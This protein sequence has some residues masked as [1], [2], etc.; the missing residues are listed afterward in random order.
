MISKILSGVA[1]CIATSLLLISCQK[2]EVY[3]HS[4]NAVANMR[5][6]GARI[7]DAY[8]IARTPMIISN[9]FLKESY[10]I[11][12][13][14]RGKP[15]NIL[16]SLTISSPLNNAGVSGIINIIA[17]ATDNVGVTRV[18]F[19]IDATLIATRTA[20]PYTAS[21]NSASVSNGAH[22]I[23]VSALDAAGNIKTVTVNILVSN[24]QAGDITN[25]T[26]VITS[27]A[28]NST[29]SGNVNVAASASDNIGV[30]SVSYSVDGVLLGTDDSAPYSVIWN[31][32]GTTTG[33]HIL[34]ATALDA[35]GNSS[36]SSITVVYNTIILPPVNL[37]SSMILTTPTP[38]N[39]GN[40][41]S[42]AAFAIG[43]GARSIEQYY[44]TNATSYSVS[45]NVFS[46]E[47]VFN[48]ANPGDCG[49]GTSISI[50]L[51]IIKN[52]GIATW[53]SMP[54]SD[55]NGCAL[56]PDGN[57]NA[58]AANYK[59]SGYSTLPHTD[60]VAIKT[61]ISQK[62]PV[63][64]TLQADNSFINAGP[65]FIWNAYSGSGMLAHIVIIVG[66]DDARNAY[67]IMNSW[68]TGWADGGYSWID[69]DFFPQRSSYNTFV[70][71]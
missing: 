36:T 43:Y 37:P 30:A 62:H 48:V 22:I 4:D 19:K 28:N 20:P 60:R 39:Q 65:G 6:G 24:I 67:K 53:Q 29:V 54:Y 63:I 18:D 1:V 2:D 58:N 56:M 25:P 64:V 59:I 8:V 16:P 45:N 35:A 15:D 44:R 34:A 26:V 40:E 70:I 71:Q 69:Y 68:G 12:E 38:G 14:A 21:W 27:P 7:D 33:N 9:E 13:S 3:K 66:Y 47:Y 57:Q 17:A 46:P 5:N 41:G 10:N 61:M 31:T 55:L 42:C 52:Q 50:V 11:E 23:Q 32:A 51:N 49:L